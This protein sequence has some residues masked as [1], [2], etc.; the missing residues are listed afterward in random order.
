MTWRLALP[1]ILLLLAMVP[2]KAEDQTRQGRSATYALSIKKTRADKTH[3]RVSHRSTG[4]AVWQRTFD[5]VSDATWT[6]DGKALALVGTTYSGSMGP[7]LLVWR[8]GAIPKEYGDL[9][10]LREDGLF[11][12][13]WS[14]DGTGILFHTAP[15]HGSLTL[16]V[17][18]AWCYHPRTKALHAVIGGAGNIYQARWV[19]RSRIRLIHRNFWE[20]DPKR[21]NVPNYRDTVR[22]VRCS[23]TSTVPRSYPS[24]GVAT[25]REAAAI[26]DRLSRRVAWAPPNKSYWSDA[27]ISVLVP[28]INGP[29][30]WPKDIDPNIWPQGPWHYLVEHK[31]LLQNFPDGY[32]R[33]DRALTRAEL[34]VIVARCLNRSGA[35]PP[36]AGDPPWFRDIRGHEWYIGPMLVAYR[37]G[38]MGGYPDRTFRGGQPV[39]RSELAVTVARLVPLLPSIA[40]PRKPVA[41]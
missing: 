39:T 15:A 34:A 28:S 6:T 9:R 38:M 37:S 22:V 19:D 26:L 32:Y 2:A 14:P 8:E 18:H 16:G 23:A 4:R 5:Y 17:G 3:V 21:P 1:L 13:A 27:L 31:G 36:N 12:L 25:R 33:P 40:G 10:P 29:A 20:Y 24:S 35:Q 41:P 7:R 11:S 30:A